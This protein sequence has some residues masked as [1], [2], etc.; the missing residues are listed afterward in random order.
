VDTRNWLPG[1]KVLVS[2]RWFR[3]VNW[4]DETIRVELSRNTIEN[5]PEYDP[6]TLN[7]GYEA[8]LHQHYGFRPYWE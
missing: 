5:S 7:R 1:K 2:A 6:E 8:R 4:A 3:D